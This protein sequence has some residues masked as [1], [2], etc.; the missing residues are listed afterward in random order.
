LPKNGKEGP[1]EV[2]IFIARDDKKG[3][4]RHWLIS[5]DQHYGEA[6]KFHLAQ[7]DIPACSWR[8]VTPTHSPQFQV[9]SPSFI[10]GLLLFLW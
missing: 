10:N 7:F 6:W 3:D 1:P 8:L 4:A 2:R 9:L 5:H